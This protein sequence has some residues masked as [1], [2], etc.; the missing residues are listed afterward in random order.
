MRR[1]GGGYPNS[2]RQHEA[3]NLP[4]LFELSYR[5]V[6]TS[7]LDCSNWHCDKTLSQYRI[8][9]SPQSFPPLWWI[10]CGLS[11]HVP[12]VAQQSWFFCTSQQFEV[13]PSRCLRLPRPDRKCGTVEPA[14]SVAARQG[15]CCAG[16][17]EIHYYDRKLVNYLFMFSP[18]L[19]LV[20]TFLIV[21]PQFSQSADRTSSVQTDV[22]CWVI[23]LY[24]SHCW[25]WPFC[26]R[27]E[28]AKKQ[29]IKK[30]DT[31]NSVHLGWWVNYKF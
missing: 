24:G 4:T 30:M 8:Q 2:C 9:C 29:R 11:V 19:P 3:P 23:R 12:L 27:V 21:G 10:L 13:S 6:R 14:S 18:V 1:K 15:Q 28:L 7:S 26:L 20:P 25:P 16:K 22:K 17:A 5:L 31:N